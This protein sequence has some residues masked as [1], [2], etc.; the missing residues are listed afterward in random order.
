MFKIKIA[1]YLYFSWIRRES[2]L[3]PFGFVFA[4]YK[5]RADS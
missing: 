5:I 2:M 4:M 3:G 1:T